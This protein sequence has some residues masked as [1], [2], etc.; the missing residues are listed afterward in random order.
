MEIRKEARGKEKKKRKNKGFS[1]EFE[2]REKE[3]ASVSTS[4]K[5]DPLLLLDKDFVPLKVQLEVFFFSFFL[6]TFL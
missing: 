4:C 3:I 6:D 5:N 1:Q 2:T